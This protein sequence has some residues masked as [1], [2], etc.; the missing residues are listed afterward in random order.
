MN[1]ETEDH[2]VKRVVCYSPHKR[3]LLEEAEAN[4][5]GLCI[6][7][8]QIYDNGTIKV[9]DNSSI[10]N[11]ALGFQPEYKMNPTKIDCVIN[12]TPLE[13][14]VNV[15]GM[16]ILHE[17]ETVESGGSDIPIQKGYLCDETGNVKLV[18]WR[19][20]TQVLENRASYMLCNVKKIMWNNVVE[21]QT[22]PTTAFRQ[23]EPILDYVQPDD[24]IMSHHYNCS[25]IAAK[26]V[27]TTKCLICD[28]MITVKENTTSVI[29]PNRE[30]EAST[31]VV[32]NEQKYWT[33][34]VNN[35][36]NN[37]KL[38]IK[39]H[40]LP[41][42]KVDQM[43]VYFRKHKFDIDYCPVSSVVDKITQIESTNTET[44]EEQVNT[45]T[46]GQANMEV[47]DQANIPDVSEQGSGTV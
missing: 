47:Q 22:T 24:E 6:T 35:G 2:S 46:Q 9:G 13:A 21:L 3:R 45:E 12:E 43:R 25:I 44:E 38:D 8:V 11:E 14:I 20:Y 7:K 16:V 36:H 10:R 37:I 27:H 1:V 39:S 32:K 4:K 34:V 15:A 26:Y 17:P 41:N 33:V 23:I 40:L 19:E 30:C 5:T 28:K 31:M 42:L 18:L 29:C